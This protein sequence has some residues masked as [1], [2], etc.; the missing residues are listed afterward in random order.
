ML[1]I[2]GY[3]TIV[4]WKADHKQNNKRDLNMN[5]FIN[6]T[7]KLIAVSALGIL[8]T[9]CAPQSSAFNDIYSSSS[10]SSSAVSPTAITKM[11]Y[12]F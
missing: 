7:K 8:V 12:G 11:N 3:T 2:N 6:T 9:A 10:A 4:S 1:L 5:A